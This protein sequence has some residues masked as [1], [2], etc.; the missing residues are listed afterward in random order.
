LFAVCLDFNALANGLE[1][2]AAGHAVIEKFKVRVLK[3]HDPP[4]IDAHQVVVRGF[5][6]EVRVIGCLIVT[7]INFSQKIGFN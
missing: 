7:E 5:I 3:L 1:A 4:A 2:E 6:V